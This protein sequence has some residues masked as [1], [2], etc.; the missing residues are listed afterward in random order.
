MLLFWRAMQPHFYFR[1]RQMVMSEK[2]YKVTLTP[3]ERNALHEVLAS[4]FRSERE[5][6]R[7]Q[8][9]LLSDTGL[10]REEGGSLT[11][12]EVADRLQ[13]RPLMVHEVRKRACKWRTSNGDGVHQKAGAHSHLQ[14][15]SRNASLVCASFTAAS[16]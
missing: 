15:V 14:R 5:K 9:L 13:C 3:D 4:S 10:S 7:A 1:A 11:D 12:R 8:A 6:K 2:L 16:R